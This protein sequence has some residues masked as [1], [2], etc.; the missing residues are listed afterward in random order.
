M[1]TPSLSIYKRL[2][3]IQGKSIVSVIF[4]LNLN[5]I[6]E[7]TEIKDLPMGTFHHMAGLNFL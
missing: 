3:L 1:E 7:G 5:R 4:V 6:L 2:I